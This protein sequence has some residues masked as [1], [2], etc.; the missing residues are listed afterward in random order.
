MIGV[1]GVGWLCVECHC[2]GK[3]LPV[4]LIANAMFMFRKI[5]L[6]LFTE[7]RGFGIC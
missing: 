7:M 2:L 6:S 4:E 3:S 1:F 5:T